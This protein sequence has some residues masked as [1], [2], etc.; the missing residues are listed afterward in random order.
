MPRPDT[1]VLVLKDSFAIGD[2]GRIIATRIITH[3][4]TPAAITF[5]FNSFM[6]LSLL[7]LNE[8]TELQ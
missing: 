6:I 1:N 3:A 4:A 5:L 7:G 8:T 2:F